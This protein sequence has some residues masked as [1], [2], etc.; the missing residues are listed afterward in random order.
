MRRFAHFIALLAALATL[1]GCAWRETDR[2]WVSD[3]RFLQVWNH[4]QAVGSIHEIRLLL[5]DQPWRLGEIN[6]CLYRIGQLERA[7]ELHGPLAF[8]P[9]AKPQAR[10]GTKIRLR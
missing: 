6:E 8:P 9:R 2:R 5:E 4:H 10:P 1:A 3:Q 7:Q